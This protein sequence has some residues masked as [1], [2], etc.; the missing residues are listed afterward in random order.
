[1]VSLRFIAQQ[2][3][4]KDLALPWPLAQGARYLEPFFTTL[5]ALYW[6]DGYQVMISF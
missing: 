2:V 5:A 3:N 6:K 1:M 4:G